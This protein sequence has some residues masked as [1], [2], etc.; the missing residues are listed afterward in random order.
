MSVSLINATSTSAL[1]ALVPPNVNFDTYVV[2][3]QGQA[4]TVDV[5]IPSTENTL[6]VPGLMPGTNYTVSVSTAVAQGTE[7]EVV[8][9]PVSLDFTTG[10]ELAPNPS[11]VV[12]I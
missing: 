7:N 8:S 9:E 1:F 4:L 5:S 2:K 11:K 12:L 6:S 3:V 10:N